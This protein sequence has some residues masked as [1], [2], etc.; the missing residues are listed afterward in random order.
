MFRILFRISPALALCPPP[1]YD[2]AEVTMTDSEI[3][4]LLAEI[5]TVAIIGA[6][7][8][9]GQP[10]DR[11]GRYLLAAGYTVLPVHPARKEVWGLAAR[12]TMNDL[13]EGPEAVVLFR[14]PEYC[15]GHAREALRLRPLPRVFWM[16]EGI[17]SP[18]A[19]ALLAP[20]G[21]SVLSNVCILKEHERLLAGRPLGSL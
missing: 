7:D 11:V 16:Q 19:E 15:A 21:V 17:S 9:P 18:E 20:A 12:P 2:G 6:K 3:R 8:K 1:R 13:P 5:K 10:V 4:K 14:A